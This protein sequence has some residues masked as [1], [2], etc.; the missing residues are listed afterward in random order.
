[1]LRTLS[2]SLK[3]ILKG[4]LRAQYQADLV[5][6]DASLTEK[7]REVME[8]ALFQLPQVQEALTKEAKS[9]IGENGV[10]KEGK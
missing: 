2:M 9:I 7:G 10:R 5:N 6:E 4:D 1:M 8:D 3:R